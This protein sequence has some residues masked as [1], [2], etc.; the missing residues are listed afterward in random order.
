MGFLSKNSKQNRDE[1]ENKRAE[2]GVNTKLLHSVRTDDDYKGSTIVPI[3]QTTAFAHDTAKELE[4]V[5][6]GRQFGFAYSRIGNPT[7]ENFQKRMATLE[8]GIA[9]TA[10]SSGSAAVLC[11]LLTILKSGDEIIVPTGLYG[12]TLDLFKDL[13]PLGIKAVFVNDFTP[14][15]V[16]KQ[17]TPSTKAIFSEVIGNPKLNVI[18][19][20]S[21]AELAHNNDIPLIVDATTATPVLVKPISLGADIVLHSSS[22]YIC[23][24]GSAISGVIIDAGNFRW[25]TKKFAVM[26]DYLRY[27]KGAFTA[28][29]RNSI[30]RDIGA[31]LSPM[32][33]YLNI[34]GLETLGLRMERICSNALKLSEFFKTHKSVKEVNYPGLPDNPYNPLVK[35]QFKDALAGGILTIRTGNKEMAYSVIDNLRYALN[36]S[37]IGDTKTLVVHPSSTIFA[38]SSKSEKTAAGVYDDMIRISVGIEDIENI[39]DDF[40]RALHIADINEFVNVGAGI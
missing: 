2:L 30:W 35:E 21:L 15:N 23:G 24:N 29:L 40:D 33:A 22:K 19:I 4:E 16:K 37:N 28:R 17:I 8:G 10:C 6:S 34:N 31:C 9:A 25:R 18:D 36:A 5:F 20:K 26:G 13:A 39:I 7:I 12:G 27:G 3:F 14:E 1:K 32:N 11:T 38:H